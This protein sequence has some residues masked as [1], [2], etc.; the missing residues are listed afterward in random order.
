MTNKKTIG[1]LTIATNQYI[2]YWQDLIRS[3]NLSLEKNLN[4]KFHVFTDMIDIAQNFANK[5]SQYKIEIHKIEH[6]DWPE[7]TLFRYKIFYNFKDQLPEPILMHID[8]DSIFTS[9]FESMLTEI[10]SLSDINFVMHPGYFRTKKY[11]SWVNGKGIVIRLKDLIMYIKIGG[12]GAWETRLKSKAFVPRNK[13]KK[14]FCGAVWFGS[15]HE[16]LKFCKILSSRIEDDLSAGLIAKW[17]DESHL[18]W[19]AAFNNHKYNG[20]EF[21]YDK[22]YPNLKNL[23][24]AIIAVRKKSL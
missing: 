18:N 19:Y 8:A 16:I 12:I 9:N 17:H 15:R 4:L 3:Y 5:M 20:P 6:L 7:A 14:Y 23:T 24:P 1:I 10:Q 2:Y 21:C 13:R 11:F 22:Y